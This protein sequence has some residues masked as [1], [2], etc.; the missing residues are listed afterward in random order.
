MKPS[1]QEVM[2]EATRLTR[3]GR[4][5]DATSAIQRALGASLFRDHRSSV[6]PSAEVNAPSVIHLPAA[7][8]VEPAPAHETPAVDV[9]QPPAPTPGEARFLSGS[10]TRAGLTRSY[11]L[12]LPPVAPDR[13]LPL[14]V[15]L[16]G[17]TQDPDDFAAGTD[18]NG[19][20]E[21]LGFAVLY[22]AQARQAN[23]SKCWNWF[24]HNH[25]RR[26]DGEPALI[27]A[28]TRAVIAE[29]SIDPQRVYIAGL[30]AG[31]AMAALVAAAYPDLYAA[32]GVHS[33]LAPGAAQSLPEAMSAMQG[34][35]RSSGGGAPGLAVPVIVFHG[36]ADRTVHPRNGDEVVASALRDRESAP[37]PMQ[38]SS[39]SETTRGH[40]SNGQAFTRHVHRDGAGRPSV[41]Q[42]VLHGAGH[43]WAGGSAD[44]SFTD[45]AGPSASREMLRFFLEHPRIAA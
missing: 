22:P 39:A 19:L 24:K 26:E 29:H 7:V 40:S 43:A 4:L 2:R 31:G 30:S 5:A 9:G 28:M 17:C 11:K 14:V 25:Q 42:W 44:G 18:M 27:A 33:G 35:A 45:P 32:V 3:T 36:D 1:F 38:P 21:E 34:A 37:S 10:H 41:E 20:A 15:M 16:H 8:A 6:P 12:F 13:L 23:P